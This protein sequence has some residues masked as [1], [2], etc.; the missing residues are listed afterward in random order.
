MVA[1]TNVLTF[2]HD[3]W[4]RTFTDVAKDYPE[5][6]TAYEHID[7][8]CMRM[9]TSPER[10]DVIATTNMFG[11]I[12]TDLGAILQGG[13]GLAASANLNPQKTAPSM[14]EPGLIVARLFGPP[15]ASGPAA[16]PAVASWLVT[17]GVPA[18]STADSPV[19][20]R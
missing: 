11:D 8:C 12:V 10:Y 1:K 5:I 9:V 6:K 2:A 3:L 18:G 14:F 19:P 20:A 15:G 13:M 17:S 4:M 7:A 16:R